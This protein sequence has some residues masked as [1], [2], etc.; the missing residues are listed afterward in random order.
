MKKSILEVLWFFF[1]A[2][3]Q[4]KNAEEPSSHAWEEK[5]LVGCFVKAFIFSHTLSKNGFELMEKPGF[6]PFWAPTASP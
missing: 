3:I 1:G 4:K 6:W 5:M 2:E